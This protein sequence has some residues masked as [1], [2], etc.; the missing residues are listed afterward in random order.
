MNEL[1]TDSK[2]TQRPW[3]FVAHL[4]AS[5]NHRGF[6]IFE[7]SHPSSRIADVFPVDSEGEIGEA[8]A[9]LIAAAPD[10]LAALENIENDDKNMPASAWKMIQDAIAKAR[11]EA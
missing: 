2:Y 1:R 3:V 7:A 6:S 10:M 9:R 11:G 5:E 4:T 8:N